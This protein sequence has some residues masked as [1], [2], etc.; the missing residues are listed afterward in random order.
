ML[1][2]G[3][4]GNTCLAYPDHLSR[5]IF[6]ITYAR[7]PLL[8]SHIFFPTNSAT[9]HQ[10]MEQGPLPYC[11]LAFSLPSMPHAV[12]AESLFSR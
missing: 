12:C 3:N 2:L 11:P 5:L 9:S 7:K 8:T 10:E 1:V 4:Q 6:S